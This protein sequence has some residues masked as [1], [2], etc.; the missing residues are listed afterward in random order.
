MN[1]TRFWS[2]VDAA[3]NRAGDNED[4][5]APVLGAALA[6]LPAS[7]IQSFQRIY[8][9]LILRANRWDLWGAAYLMMGGCSDDSFRYFRDWLIS[10][11]KTAYEG[12]L[13]DPDS[14]ADYP[15]R[16]EFELENFGYAAMEA[17][18]EQSD[19]EL[20]REPDESGAPE[21]REWDPDDLPV[22]LPRL[23]EKYPY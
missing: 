10:E 6:A 9:G 5:R 23:A 2:L 12:A 11:G 22:L 17:Y 21:G 1:E 15:A 13:A 20:E 16:D 8:D 14:L 18:A 7:E 3:R 19:D 4:A